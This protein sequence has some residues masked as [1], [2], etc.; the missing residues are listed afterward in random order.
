MPVLAKCRRH[1]STIHNAIFRDERHL[2]CTFAR[3]FEA[4][5]FA[6]GNPTAPWILPDGFWGWIRTIVSRPREASAGNTPASSSSCL[7]HPGI[8]NVGETWMRRFRGASSE[9]SLVGSVG[10]VRPATTPRVD[11]VAAGIPA[12]SYRLF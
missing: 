7:E 4:V 9:S 8:D 5:Y 11:L 10:L 1:P 12:A 2:P 3:E 6:A